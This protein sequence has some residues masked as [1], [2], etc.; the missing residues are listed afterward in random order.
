MA[1][2]VWAVMANSIAVNLSWLRIVIVRWRTMTTAR[3]LLSNIFTTRERVQ[4]SIKGNRSYLG[5]RWTQPLCPTALA[6]IG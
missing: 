2:T 4:P 3:N 6:V 1:Y 5:S